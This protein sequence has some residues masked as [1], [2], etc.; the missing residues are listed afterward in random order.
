MEK[1]GLNISRYSFFI[2]LMKNQLH[3]DFHRF[4]DVSVSVSKLF[5]FFG[6]FRFALKKLGM[7]KTTDLVLKKIGMEKV[8]DSVS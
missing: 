8:S 5:N 7:K 3:I 1:D 4:C 2:L 6:G